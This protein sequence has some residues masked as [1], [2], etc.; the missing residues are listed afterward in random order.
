MNVYLGEIGINYAYAYGADGSGGG[1][2]GYGISQHVNQQ[3]RS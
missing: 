2:Y 1:V 3:M